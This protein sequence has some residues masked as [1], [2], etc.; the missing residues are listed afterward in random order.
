SDRARGDGRHRG[1]MA[2]ERAVGAWTSVEGGGRRMSRP[3]TLGGDH[4]YDAS[5]F[6]STLPHRVLTPREN[7]FGASSPS[8]TRPAGPP[9]AGDP[10]GRHRG[11]R[12][13]GTTGREPS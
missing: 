8:P 6:V 7:E 9:L 13:D 10:S 4:C 12:H 1:S 5:T 11:I 2:D 3:L